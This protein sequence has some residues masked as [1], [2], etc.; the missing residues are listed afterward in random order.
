M[1]V[2]SVRNSNSILARATS[3]FIAM[4]LMSNLLCAQQPQIALN[5][6]SSPSAQ[7]V[8]PP[9]AQMNAALPAAEKPSIFIKL[10]RFQKSVK[11]KMK[12]TFSRNA[13]TE[14]PATASRPAGKQAL[15]TSLYG[16]NPPPGATTAIQNWPTQSQ[17]PL[18]QNQQFA[19]QF[20]PNG[21]Y[22]NTAA[23][24]QVD[25]ANYQLPGSPQ[26]NP[27][28]GSAGQYRV[29]AP[30][31]GN[32]SLQ[33]PM[34][35]TPSTQY[36]STQFPSP[37]TT[38]NMGGVPNSGMQGTSAFP[39]QQPT[40]PVGLPPT[41]YGV[42]LGGQQVTAT[43]HAL[44]LKE[45]NEKLTADRESLIQRNM[46]LQR[47][48]EASKTMIGKLNAALADVEK[49]LDDADSTN[50]ALRQQLASLRSEHERSL[51]ATDRMLDSLRSELDDMLMR[52]IS[53]E[54]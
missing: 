13:D 10:D 6:F 19:N 52:E 15:A 24:A 22:A 33:Q 40:A 47:E 28:Q 34:P 1:T 2:I 46:R 53:V 39:G 7:V 37:Q 12:N 3:T 18:S 48:L 45:E 54:P 38:Q 41:S 30:M 50:R 49:S 27:T 44:R 25:L 31:N 8:S 35:P 32:S 29:N 51:L 26:A 4:L 43:E 9:P 14:S 36:P 20:A 21:Q 11:Q 42:Q 17:P 16:S 23:N 5:Q